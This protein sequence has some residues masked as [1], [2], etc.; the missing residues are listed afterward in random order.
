M[1]VA[2]IGYGKM[3]HA[4]ESILVSRG[5]E[6]SLIVDV[7]NRND[8][9][10]ASAKNVDVAIEFSAPD[11]AFDNIMSCLKL[12]IPVVSGTTAWLSRFDEVKSTCQKLNGAFFYSSNY[13]IGV[14]VFFKAN[15]YLAKLMNKFS[16]YDVTVEETHHSEKKDA[17]SGTAITT[18]EGILRNL[19]RKDKWCLG[20]PSDNSVLEVSAV[21]RSKVKGIHT[22]TWENELEMIEITHMAHSRDCF[23]QGAVMAAEFLVGKKG[24][25]GMDDLLNL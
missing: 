16:G 17:P 15:E 19:D 6:I 11:A 25:F 2:I 5:H 20:Q 10:E 1:R 3:G 23:A 9:N 14:N 22:V 8:L 12:N 7:D 18:A 4:I 21:R 24:I 13:S